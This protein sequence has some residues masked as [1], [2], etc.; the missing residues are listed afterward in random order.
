MVGLQLLDGFLQGVELFLQGPVLLILALEGFVGSPEGSQLGVKRAEFLG[1]LTL[2]GINI[3]PEL[4][5][6][7][8]KFGISGLRLL[9]AI[10][11]KIKNQ[12]EN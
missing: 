6:L 7:L 1:M 12:R 4:L 10:D 8:E 9:S 2:E 11:R 5:V 3:V